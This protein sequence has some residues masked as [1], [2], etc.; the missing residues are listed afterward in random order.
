MCLFVHSTKSYIFPYQDISLRFPYVYI[1]IYYLAIPW[2]FWKVWVLQICTTNFG[3]LVHKV[4][5]ISLVETQGFS[6]EKILRM[7]WESKGYLNFKVTSA[8]IVRDRA[9]YDTVW[10]P[11]HLVEF[12]G[13]EEK[14]RR[15]WPAMEMF[16][17]GEI[18]G[19]IST[20]P[21]ISICFLSLM[22]KHTWPNG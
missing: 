4:L 18:V 16:S 7:I 9:S 22:D 11:N 5:Q 15:V 17:R 14:E 8:E 21:W 2:L 12:L 3:K 19:A 6:L 13:Q 20:M 10:A 1:E